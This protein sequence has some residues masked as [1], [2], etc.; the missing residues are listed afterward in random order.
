MRETDPRWELTCP[1]SWTVLKLRPEFQ[2]PVSQFTAVPTGPQLGHQELD[3]DMGIES[4]TKSTMVATSLH[5]PQKNNS[6]SW[7]ISL[8]S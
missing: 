7:E 2:S 1:P 5:L 8:S 4:G 3:R 6:M